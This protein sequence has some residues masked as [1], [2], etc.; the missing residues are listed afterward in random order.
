MRQ[1]N[2]TV[3]IKMTFFSYHF[4]KVEHNKR[5]SKKNIQQ[6]N[7]YHFSFTYK[8]FGRIELKVNTSLDAA[9]EQSFFS[10]FQQIHLFGHPVDKKDYYRLF[11]N[12]IKLSHNIDENTQIIFSANFPETFDKEIFKKAFNEEFTPTNQLIMVTTKHILQSIAYFVSK[13]KRSHVFLASPQFLFVSS[14][15]KPIENYS[16]QILKSIRHVTK[17][18]KDQ[19]Y[20]SADILYFFI[21]QFGF[22][23]FDLKYLNIKNNNYEFSKEFML[24]IKQRLTS[25]YEEKINDLIKSDYKRK[26][27]VLNNF[28][29]RNIELPNFKK[30]AL[31]FSTIKRA[32]IKYVDFVVQFNKDHKKDLTELRKEDNLVYPTDKKMLP[33]FFIYKLFKGSKL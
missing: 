23:N 18:I 31:Y 10:L 26:I 2:S 30:K 25:Y 9:I 20:I 8:R 1:N 24:N 3:I 6:D 27:Y 11:L 19:P 16:E 28:W 32:F 22:E 4:L 5:F 29:S 17:E 21:S 12:H 33:R 14:D 13:K 15:K 7:E